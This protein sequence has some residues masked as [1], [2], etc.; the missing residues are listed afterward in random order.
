[1]RYQGTSEMRSELMRLKRDRSSGRIVTAKESAPEEFSPAP[2][3]PTV[4]ASG[5]D[6]R[7]AIAATVGIKSISIVLTAVLIVAVV[8][9][10]FYL[11]TDRK[12]VV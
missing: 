1:L 10:S 7:S 4:T 8:G 9:I 11:W 2:P 5:V 6:R 3:S 12:S